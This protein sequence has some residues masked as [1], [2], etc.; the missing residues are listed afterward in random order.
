MV[1]PR[2]YQQ[3][4][5]ASLALSIVMRMAVMVRLKTVPTELLLAISRILMTKLGAI[6]PTVV[7][8]R[9]VTVEDHTRIVIISVGWKLP[10]FHS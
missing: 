6:S 7:S 4:N 2:K 10:M 1:L 8:N 5:F 9:K 3:S